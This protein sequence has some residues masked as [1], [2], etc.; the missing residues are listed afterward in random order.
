MAEEP[1][2]MCVFIVIFQK[3]HFIFKGKL[4]QSEF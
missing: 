1:Q 4:R 2:N 3:I